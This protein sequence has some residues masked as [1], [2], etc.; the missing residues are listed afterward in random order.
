MIPLMVSF[1]GKTVIIFGGG[2]VAARKAAFFSREARVRVF[3]RSFSEELEPVSCEKKHCLV[4][5]LTDREV[6]NLVSGVFLVVGALSD[7]SENDRIGRICREK[8]VLFNNAD[9]EAGDVVVPSLVE[10]RNFCIAVSTGGK[11]P[12]IPRFIRERIEAS[13][14]ALDVMI[15]LQESLR[16]LLKESA[17]SQEKRAELLNAVLRDDGVWMMAEKDPAL[18]WEIVEARYG[19]P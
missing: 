17:I 10:G 15:D 19:S 2:R 6:R 4:D 9:G 3:S 8:G 5:S 14:P 12:A 18:A 1:A 7:S 11:S 13:Y 16:L